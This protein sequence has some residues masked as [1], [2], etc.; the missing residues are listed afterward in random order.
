MKNLFL[1]LLLT[2]GLFSV[3]TATAQATNNTNEAW[4]INY[5]GATTFVAAGAQNV[6][7]NTGINC[8]A[9]ISVR[10][11]TT[12]NC[13]LPITAPGLFLVPC[14]I[15]TNSV[16]FNGVPGGI[17]ILCTAAAPP[18]YGSPVFFFN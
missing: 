15:L 8:L 2:A 18:T 11:L 10:S 13:G 16:A 6:P 3:Q 5:Y 1:F 17:A 12:P 7:I 14:S 4:I 9:G